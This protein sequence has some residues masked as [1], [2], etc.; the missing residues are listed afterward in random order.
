MARSSWNFV[1]SLS[2]VSLV[3]LGALTG[4]L[5]GCQGFTDLQDLEL[6]RAE[7]RYV[8]TELGATLGV[9]LMD[10][11]E[12]SAVSAEAQ[13]AWI[14]GEPMNEDGCAN[15][16]IVD[17]MSSTDLT[18]AVRFDFP[19]CDGRSGSVIVSQELDL[20]MGDIGDLP[21]GDLP[22]GE[23]PDLPDGT[24]A[25][26]ADAL[27]PTA[28]EDG[29]VGI[30]Y[31]GYTNGLLRT[32]GAM[33]MTEEGDAGTLDADLRLAALD[34]EGDIDVS[35]DWIEM[36]D[37]LATRLNVTGAFVSVTGVEW[38]VMANNVVFQPGCMD[39][40]G[41]SLTLVHDNPHGRVTVEALFD[42]TC[43]GCATLLVNGEEQATSCF[44][45]GT[46][47]GGF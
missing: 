5:S 20:D 1:S 22:P 40:L 27:D 16:G 33:L 8:P 18:G 23:E 31:A 45:D 21:E 29:S 3:A 36:A 14:N 15:V 7:A 30:T 12:Y 11:R 19:N 25:D 26:V 35:G 34:Y 42:A 2:A 47:I 43:D 39:G 37:G 38:T 24:E 32:S 28:I 41:G 4:G 10:A 44:G 46:N 6:A 13:A 17:G 9:A